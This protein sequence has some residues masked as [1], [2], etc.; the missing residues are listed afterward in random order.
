LA[1]QDL[2]G[3]IV[4]ELSP[5]RQ[6]ELDVK[7]LA[8][9]TE[10]LGSKGVNGIFVCGTTGEGPIMTLAERKRAAEVVV[11][12]S[13]VPVIIHSGTNNVEDTIALGRHA[14]DVG[15]AAHAAVTPMF[16]PYTTAGLVSYFSNVGGS[17]DLPFFVYSNP[18]RAN[19]KMAAEVFS[20]LSP[21]GSSP[22]NVVGV[23]ES[24]GDM[25]YLGRVIQSV[26]RDA[27]VF[28]GADACF[29]P[30]LV[31]GTRGQVSGYANL[32]PELYVEMYEAWKRRDT[33]AAMKIQTRISRVRAL[34][35]VPYI[36]PIKEGLKL[37]GIDAGDVKPPLVRMD[38]K[39][40]ETLLRKLIELEPGLFDKGS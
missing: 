1:I 32:A 16:Y 9:L 6:G 34:L 8:G 24:S 19:V 20:H 12:R 7:L 36:Q 5:F 30:G 27:L 10:F 2:A 11:E 17:C 22:N 37:R 23:K 29:L 31:L 28:N 15:A 35:E 40:V 33:E 13:T 26:S 39:E 14:K 25:A 21:G 3:V 4:A 18:T 38:E